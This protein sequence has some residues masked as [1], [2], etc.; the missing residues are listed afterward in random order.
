MTDLDRMIAEV[1]RY[2]GLA[3]PWSLVYGLLREVQKLRDK[4]EKLE[5]MEQE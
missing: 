3:V 5:G 1:E 2:R 4:L